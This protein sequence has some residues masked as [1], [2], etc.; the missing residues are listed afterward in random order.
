MA[1]KTSRK[2]LPLVNEIFPTEILK[3]I[4]ENL[5]YKSLCYA[6]GVCKHWKEII[7]AFELLEKA[8]SNVCFCILCN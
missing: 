1:Y 8:L 7:N 5:D 4:L 3:K 6:K 2:D